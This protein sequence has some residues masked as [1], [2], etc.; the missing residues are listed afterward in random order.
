M[1]SI[2]EADQMRIFNLSPVLRDSG[3]L[4]ASNSLHLPYSN[5]HTTLQSRQNSGNAYRCGTHTLHGTTT[6]TT[7]KSATETLHLR[8]N[9]VSL[10]VVL[11]FQSYSSPFVSRRI[12]GAHQ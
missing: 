3:C 1:R 10:L 2:H 9:A 5:F 7:P 11:M 4:I 8:Y 12:D 6:G